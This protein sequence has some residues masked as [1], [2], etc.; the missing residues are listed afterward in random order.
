MQPQSPYFT[1][2]NMPTQDFSVL[3]NAGRAWA[4]A[5]R[6]AGEAIAKIGSSYF[7][8]QGKMKQAENFAKTEMGKQYLMKSGGFTPEQIENIA[9]DPKAAQK[10]IYDAQREAGGIDKLM[11]Q[12]NAEYSFTRLKEVNAQKDLQHEQEI[13]K[14]KFLL[15]KLGQEQR[16][17]S[18]TNSYFAHLYSENKD[19]GKRRIDSEDPT[20]GFDVSTPE[21]MQAVMAVNKQLGLGVHNPA[22][23]STLSDSLAPYDEITGERLL[24]KNFANEAEMYKSLDDLFS[25]PAGRMLP[26]EQR[27]ALTERMRSNI[28]GAGDRPFVREIFKSELKSSGFGAFAEAMK[29]NV[30]SMGNFRALIDESLI[31]KEDG[32]VGIKNPV[33]SSVALMQMA[34]IAQG[35]GVLSNQDVNLIKGDQ[36][37]AASWERL[38]EKNIGE[39]IELTED[40]IN[41]NPAWQNSINPDTGE[42]FQVGDDVYLGGANLSAADMKMFQQLADALDNRATEFQ[43]K[44]IPDI[45][46]NVRG[47][48]GGFTTKELNQFTDLHQYMPNGIVNLNPMSQVTP[49]QLD[50]VYRMM[51]DG[52]SKEEAASTIRQNSMMDPNTDY[53]D[54]S[55]GR[56]INAMVD[57]VYEKGYRPR[58]NSHVQTFNDQAQYQGKARTVNPPRV[59]TEKIQNELGLTPSGEDGLSGMTKTIAGAG[60]AAL[61]IKGQSNLNRGNAIEALTGEPS[62]RFKEANRKIAKGSAKEIRSMAQQ[63]G[64]DPKKFPNDKALRKAMK[65]ALNAKV[66]GKVTEYLTKQG[67][68][69]TIVRKLIGTTLTGGAAGLAIGG[70]SVLYDLYDLSQTSRS[71]Q[72]SELKKI[73]S[74]YNKGSKDYKLVQEL[75]NDLNPMYRHQKSNYYQQPEIGGM[76]FPLSP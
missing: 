65:S 12:I 9:L 66:K 32:T 50:A 63:M 70:A 5:Y 15:D 61:G 51:R 62:S 30:G 76:G 29:T 28:D 11:N 57:T 23:L 24:Y 36:R 55:D 16:L 1:K 19:T 31:V 3:Q 45:Y 72:E 75:I 13:E 54:D 73:Q 8:K 53:D 27:N 69:Q 4:D 58:Q 49:K 42:V 41:Q 14:N 74:K 37:V 6:E 60:G 33:A 25:S 34:R 44:V 21:N 7:D 43:Q 22:I 71:M 59:D 39:S 64:I 56:A 48:Y 38:I 18:A 68:K 67:L 46:R 20:G 40:M 17:T 10:V 52:Y 2:I 35:A 26:P 47:T